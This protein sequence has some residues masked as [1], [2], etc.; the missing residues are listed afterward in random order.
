MSHS[1]TI[2]RRIALASGMLLLAGAASI[3][4]PPVAA[5]E[6]G[7]TAW[8]ADATA[9]VFETYAEIPHQLY[10]GFPTTEVGLASPG[11]CETFAAGYYAGVEIEEAIFGT[12][13]S[14]KNVTL[15]RASN[16]DTKGHPNKA[17]VAPSGPQG[18]PRYLAECITP[19]HGHGTARNGGFSSPG[20]SFASGVT[21]TTQKIDHDARTI[22]AE[23]TTSLN[24]LTLGG[25]LR[26]H[27]MTSYLQTVLAPGAEP[28]VTYRITLH[29]IDTGGGSPSAASGD[30]FAI[31]DGGLTLAGKDVGGSELIE[32]FNEQAK[33]HEKDL[34]VLARYGFRILAPKVTTN[35]AGYTVE[36]P[37]MDAGVYFPARQ[38]QTGQGQALR[39]AMA[40]FR[41]SY[42]E[43]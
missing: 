38:N 18:G 35:E 31:N 10:P 37:V 25:S 15:A 7:A 40:R 22:N 8:G 3:T 20:G 17:E 42:S 33:A 41:G 21:E 4:Q 27:E 34:A 30:G 14:Y 29:G 12:I 19:D 28:R 2:T 26:I 39:L 36:A 13:P 23:T 6:G 1:Q 5:A 24:D 16:P 9:R 43:L 11:Q 32:Q